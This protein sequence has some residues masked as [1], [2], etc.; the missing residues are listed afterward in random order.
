M[1][2][3]VMVCRRSGEMDDM[4][5]KIW[6]TIFVAII[7]PIFVAMWCIDEYKH[8]T[9]YFIL[10]SIIGVFVICLLIAVWIEMLVM[11]WIL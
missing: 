1:I 4:V 5:I 6:L 11:I 7:L 8:P 10:S 2:I 3:A 9:I